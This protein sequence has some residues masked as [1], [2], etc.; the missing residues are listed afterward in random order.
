MF[1]QISLSEKPNNFLS[2]AFGASLVLC[3]KSTPPS[4][5]LQK[6]EDA[7]PLVS[8]NVNFLEI[9]MGSH[10]DNPYTSR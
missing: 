7:M 2:P 9:Y 1:L 3:P 5:F 8:I 6:F 10:Q 4:Y